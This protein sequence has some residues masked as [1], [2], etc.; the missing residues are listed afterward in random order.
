MKPGKLKKMKPNI[1]SIEILNEQ[2]RIPVQAEL[3]EL[4]QKTAE[5][6]LDFENVTVCCEVSITLTDNQAIREINS[7]FRNLDKPTD[8]LSFPSGEYPTEEEACFLGDVAISLERAEEQRQEYGHTLE[9]EV[10]FL[11]A[12]SILHLL[13]YDHMKPDEEKDM[14]ER[15]EEIL[16]LIGQKR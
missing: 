4:I 1:H 5:T 15:Q 9:R 12:H 10:A 11:T 3:L 2:D 14:S 8:V 13:G 7:R 16:S 6:A